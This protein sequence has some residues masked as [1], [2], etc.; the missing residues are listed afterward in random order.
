MAARKICGARRYGDDVSLSVLA[1]CEL[2]P[3]SLPS[4][5][6]QSCFILFFPSGIDPESIP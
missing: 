1:M 4:P 3:L 2:T 5:S 6:V